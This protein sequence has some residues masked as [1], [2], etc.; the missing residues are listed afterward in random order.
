MGVYLKIYLSFNLLRDHLNI[1]G[2]RI[3]AYRPCGPELK[4]RAEQFRKH[5]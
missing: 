2:V 1:R 5:F 3:V 4:S